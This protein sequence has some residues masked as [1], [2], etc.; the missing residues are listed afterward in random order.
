MIDIE[1]STSGVTAQ[2]FNSVVQALRN[3]LQNELGTMH[4]FRVTMTPNKISVD[5]NSHDLSKG[6]LKEIVEDVLP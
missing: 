3:S 2:N 1:I 4:P 6:R 5:L